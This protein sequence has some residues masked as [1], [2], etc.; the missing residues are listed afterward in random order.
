MDGHHGQKGALI[1]ISFFFLHLVHAQDQQ[2]F[3]S[4]DCGL[5]PKKSPYTE[6]TT[7]L[8][9]TSDADFI[10]TGKRGTIAT[11]WVYTYK[12]YNALRYFPDGTRNCY[13][14]GVMQ[15]INYLIRAGFGYGNYDGRN[16]Y[17]RFDVYVGT[18]YWSTVHENDFND[19]SDQPQI[20][21]IH[22]SK[23]NSLQIC[24]VKTGT[25][26]PFIST[27]ELR[28]LQKDAYSTDPGSLK[29]VYR[30]Y[31]RPDIMMM[32]RLRYP[33]DVYDR[34]WSSNYYYPGE[35]EINT[36]LTVNSSNPFRL[37]QVIARSGAKSKNAR[38]TFRFGGG[39][40]GNPSDNIVIYL[41]FAEIENLQ[42]NDIREFDISWNG[43]ITNSAYS[44]KKL[45]IETVFN[46]SP[47]KCDGLSCDMEL[48][49]TRRSTLP[50]LLNAYE[51]YTVMEFPVSETFLDDEYRSCISTE[52][53]K[54]AW[55]SIE[56]SYSNKSTPRIIS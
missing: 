1:V 32:A 49:R 22:T 28:P 24:L 54:L 56:C 4:L 27:L 2:G 43:N 20:E 38:E 51:V 25:T 47:N 29:L 55:D 41:H 45:Q 23:S 44:P 34:Q 26:T 12:Q 15:G 39:S 35:L 33:D 9:Y 3:I 36:T 16:I 17:P 37:P 40:S 5:P 30:H 19:F 6:P 13:N 10:Q 8:N 21:I 53:N 14:L 18:N 50:P 7:K 31:Y 42:A 11:E 46:T 48:V 52:H